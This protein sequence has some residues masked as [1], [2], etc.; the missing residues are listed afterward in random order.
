M[1]SFTCP[2]CGGHLGELP[3]PDRVRENLNGQ[4]RAVFDALMNCPDGLS[5]I[6]LSLAVFGDRRG[7]SE[8]SLSNTAKIVSRVRE[9]L[10]RYGYFITRNRPLQRGVYRLIPAE[11]TP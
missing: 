5:K 1:I 11:A 8:K 3:S 9:K 4:E 10:N 2:C 6:D 7:A